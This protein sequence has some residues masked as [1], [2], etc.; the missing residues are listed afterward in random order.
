MRVVCA[1]FG[2]SQDGNG[3]TCEYGRVLFLLSEN[4]KI[5]SRWVGDNNE[6][7]EIMNYIEYN[8]V[9]FDFH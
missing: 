7:N 9:M 6:W 2:K 5:S 1:Y 3:N 8:K 4:M